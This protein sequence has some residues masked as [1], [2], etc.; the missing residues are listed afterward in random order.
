MMQ[1]DVDAKEGLCG[2]AMQASYPTA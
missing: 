2:I 1:R